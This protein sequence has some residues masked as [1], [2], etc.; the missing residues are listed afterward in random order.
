MGGASP[1]W[2]GG[3]ESSEEREAPIWGVIKGFP[4]E[5]FPHVLNMWTVRTSALNFLKWASSLL[6]PQEGGRGVTFFILRIYKTQ[7]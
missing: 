5:R 7:A 1:K 2:K 6:E 3:S 4:V